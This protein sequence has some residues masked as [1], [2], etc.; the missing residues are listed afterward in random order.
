MSR[1]LIT[2]WPLANHLNLNIAL[3]KALRDRGHDV[4]FYTGPSASPILAREGFRNFAFQ[5]VSET[6]AEQATERLRELRREPNKLK[7]YWSK[8]FVGTVPGQLQD[9]ERIRT[10][11][12]PDALVTCLTMW[13][14]ILFV[15]EKWHIPVIA[16]SHVANCLV[17]G[18]EG[19]IPGIAKPRPFKGVQKIVAKILTAVVG[20]KTAS[21]RQEASDLRVAHG[22]PPLTINVTE[23]TGSLPLYL[24]PGAPEL[25]YSR[26]DLPGSVHYIGACLWD[27]PVDQA[28]P[29]WLGGIPGDRPCVVVDEGAL[30]T[31][32]A[33][34]L[35]LAAE[36]L[37]NQPLT[38]I[39]IAGQRRQPGSVRLEKLTSNLSLYY[40]AALSGVLPHASL[41]VSNGN[42]DAVIAALQKGIPVIVLPSIWDQTEMAWAVHVSGAGLRLDTDKATPEQLRAAVEQVLRN[43][44]FRRQAQRLSAA[45]AQCGGAPRAAELVERAADGRG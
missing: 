36:A 12:P 15:P 17:P 27:K 3:A 26:K 19:A 1:I 20:R 25:D 41:L 5:D 18:P 40:D 6:E 31:Q 2:T 32:D 38:A 39:L 8:L 44:E 29:A 21:V 9:L 11:W 37:A 14:P 33:P 13:G 30:Y 10:E 4:A 34:M 7:P 45:L 24:M 42:S 23:Y 35:A 16:F 22:L 28:A 43:P